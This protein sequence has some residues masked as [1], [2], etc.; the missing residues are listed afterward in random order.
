MAP[1]FLTGEGVRDDAPDEERRA[2]LARLLTS[3]RNPWFARCYV[4]RIW[5]ALLGWGFYPGVNDLGPGHK[6]RYPEVLDLLAKKWVASGYDARWLLRTVLLTGAYQR[7]MQP[8]PGATEPVAAAVCPVPLRAEQVFENLQQALGFDENDKS[9]PAPAPSSAPAVQ[10][11]SG[12]RHMVYQAYRENPSLP[13]GEVR[14]T[15]PQALLMMNSELV[16]RQTGAAGKTALAELLAKG[17]TDEQII[18]SLFER[19]LARKPTTEEMRVCTRY[20]GKVGKRQ[21]ALEDVFWGLVN[22]TEFLIKK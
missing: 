6:S 15:I 1:R 13:F 7:Q 14:G 10:R 5:M 8:P 19:T 9:I 12:L 18:T 16:H 3:P 11:H 4:N 2:T 21:E 20:V 22:S 17:L